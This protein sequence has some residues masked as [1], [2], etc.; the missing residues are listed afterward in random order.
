MKR[1]HC[2]KLVILLTTWG[3]INIILIIIILSSEVKL[4][5]Q[6]INPFQIGHVKAF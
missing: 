5:T 6:P 4:S 1:Q 2:N 3:N